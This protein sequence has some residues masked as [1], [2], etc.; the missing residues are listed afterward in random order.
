MREFILFVDTETSGVPK[1]WKAPYDK[2]WPYIVQ[3]AWLIYSMDGKEIKS[4][5]YFIKDENIDIDPT[6]QKI[7]GISKDILL[8][9]GEKRVKVLKRLFKDIK[10]YKPLVVGHL[11][12]FDIQMITAGF[13]RAGLKN[14]LKDSLFFCTMRATS[15]YVKFRNR[16]YPRLDELY[17]ALF[18]SPM[19]DQHNALADAKAT[20]ACFFELLHRNEIT[21]EAIVQ[22]QKL[23]EKKPR[24]KTKP[25]CGL[26]VLIVLILSTVYFLFTL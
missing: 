6:A 11:I 4:E 17:E 14:I 3:I 9:K 10:Q 12:E 8:A 7:H 24:Q 25:G 2:K 13:Q 16:S 21:D 22:Q 20:A 18:K 19:A 15:H 1:D 23:F 5:S 26:P